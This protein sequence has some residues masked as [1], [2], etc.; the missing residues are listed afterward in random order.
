MTRN[1]PTLLF[2][3]VLATAQ[4]SPGTA[5]YEKANSLFVAKKFP[6]STVAVSEALQLDPNLVPALTLKAK[7]DMANNHFEQARKSLEHALSVDPKSEYAQ[8]LYGLEAYLTNEMAEA[9]PRFRKARQLNAKSPRAAL[10]LGLTCESLGQTDEAMALYR[11]AARLQQSS[12]SIDAET[13]LPG[14]RLLFLEGHLEESEKWIRL[15]LKAEP[16]FRDAH[17]ELARVLLK[18]GDAAGA[19]IEGETSLRLSGT[20]VTD[21]QIHY[22]LIRAWRANGSPEKAALQADLLRSLETPK[23]R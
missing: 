22:L 12:G 17:F 15:A 19:I 23:S 8:F 7:L 14:A 4:V 5:A 18:K 10:Y 9:L 16:K 20:I 1:I 21:A 2:A 11:D 13:V 6:E 3:A